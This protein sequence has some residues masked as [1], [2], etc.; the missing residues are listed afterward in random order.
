VRFIKCAQDLGFSLDQV[1]ELLR[2]RRSSNR[3]RTRIRALATRRIEEIERKISEL[4]RMR[5]ALRTLVHACHTGR[6]L[7]CP[8]I[9][10]LTEGRS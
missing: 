9:E 1:G 7:E 4:E 5:D 8:I 3:N 2:L 10:A 6:T